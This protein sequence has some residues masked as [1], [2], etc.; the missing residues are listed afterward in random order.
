MWREANKD[1]INSYIKNRKKTDVQFKL[2]SNLRA[3]LHRA[4]NRN[5]K[6]GSAVKDLGCTVEQLKQTFEKT[7][8][9]K[10]QNLYFDFDVEDELDTDLETEIDLEDVVFVVF[11]LVV[12]VVADVVLKQPTRIDS[13]DNTNGSSFQSIPGPAHVDGL[14]SH[15]PN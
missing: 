9:D 8:L 12:L 4:I 1:K 2:S 15:I 5:S 11:V 3:R 7:D 13:I 6:A 10:L 14:A